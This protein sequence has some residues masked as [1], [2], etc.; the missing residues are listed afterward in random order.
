M[1]TA[2]YNPAQPQLTV[3]GHANSAEYGRDLICAG[4]STLV[5]TLQRKVAQLKRDGLIQDFVSTHEKGFATVYI[6]P[7][8]NNKHI[9]QVVMRTIFC[10]FE[11][12]AESYPEYITC[13]EIPN[14]CGE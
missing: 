9:A 11:A 5:Y 10:G 7:L 1:I 2:V 6:L 3:S 13:H 12:L 14:S 8:R 4:V